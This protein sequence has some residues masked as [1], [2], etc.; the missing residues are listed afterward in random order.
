M[1]SRTSLIVRIVLSTVVGLLLFF[2]AQGTALAAD[3]SSADVPITKVI[4]YADGAGSAGKQKD[5]VLG[6]T[7]YDQIV[8]AAD[9]LQMTKSSDEGAVTMA[10]E[11]TPGPDGVCRI[12]GY[13]L[14]SVTAVKASPLIGPGVCNDLELELKGSPN[15]PG[16]I[17]EILPDTP[18]IA[19]ADFDAIPEGATVTVTNMRNDG[20]A[21]CVVQIGSIL[22]CPAGMLVG[23]YGFGKDIVPGQT[24]ANFDGEWREYT[25]DGVNYKTGMTKNPVGVVAEVIAK[26]IDPSFSLSEKDY[27]TLERIFP[28]GMPGVK[29]KGMTPR[30]ILQPQLP[31]VEEVLAPLRTEAIAP[32]L[33]NI[34]EQFNSIVEPIRAQVEKAVEPL[35]QNTIAYTS[36]DTSYEATPATY[37]APA[38]VSY[39]Q[40]V[41]NAAIAATS[42]VDDAVTSSAI[43]A[44]LGAQLNAGINDFATQ[45]FALLGGK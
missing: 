18:L 29:A 20:Y 6:D 23:H 37:S 28:Q 8:Y 5:T 36:D 43:P 44:D 27:E 31:T 3:L 7:F 25:I 12:G 41:E 38:Q 33:P 34:E 9:P 10:L 17:A 16:S 19:F 14:G 11:T 4:H 1:K 21:S 45:S 32:V 30:D 2:G 42:F 39:D 22:T 26:Q 13:S 40:I 15:G 35:L 24:Y